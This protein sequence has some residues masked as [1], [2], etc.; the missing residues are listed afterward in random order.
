M[1]GMAV[2]QRLQLSGTITTH[3]MF[4]GVGYFIDGAMFGIDF[5]GLFYVKANGLLKQQ[6]KQAGWRPYIYRKNQT[7]VTH[8]YAL[9]DDY[10]NNSERLVSLIDRVVEAAKHDFQSRLELKLRP[11]KLRDLPNMRLSTEI[12]LKQIGIATVDE[13]REIGTAQAYVWIRDRLK[14]DVSERLLFRLEG[15]LIQRHWMCLGK[16][17]Q[18]TLRERVLMLSLPKQSKN[19]R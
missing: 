8:Y 16:A 15:A 17:K 12:L 6:C 13:L 5:E 10:I 1:D 18:Q 14:L 9:P 11:T 7:I 4:S 2:I 3:P 19:Q